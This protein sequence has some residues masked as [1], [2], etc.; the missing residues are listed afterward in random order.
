MIRFGVITKQM[1]ID[2]VLERFD[3][4][5]AARLDDPYWSLKRYQLS[6]LNPPT[7]KAINRIMGNDSWT[8]LQC[9][10]C[11]QDVGVALCLSNESRMGVNYVC[12]SCL[13]FALGL[14]A[15]AL[16]RT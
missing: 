16:E 6:E 8:R 13:H 5:Y 12:P 10:H 4:Q 7:Q 3:H 9:D 15:D 2:Q 1:M 11:G 14:I